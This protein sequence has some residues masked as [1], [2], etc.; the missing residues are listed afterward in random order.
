MILQNQQ[1]ALALAVKEVSAL[2][3]TPA[4]WCI[5]AQETVSVGTNV[6][7]PGAAP[8]LRF[9]FLLLVISVAVPPNAAADISETIRARS[10]GAVTAT[11]LLHPLGS[12][13]NSHGNGRWFFSR[14]FSQGTI[15]QPSPLV[16][17]LELPDVPTFDA[18]AAQ[19]YFNAR[20]CTAV[21][22]LEGAAAI[23][24]PSGG[25]VI[26]MLCH[27]AVEHLALGLLEIFF[28][29][30]PLV[31]SLSHLFNILETVCPLTAEM[32]P[33]DTAENNR[34][35]RLLSAQP[36]SLR[37]A[38]PGKIPVADVEAI[39]SRTR[40]FLDAGIKAA[41]ERLSGNAPQVNTKS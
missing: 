11:L 12:V 22:I 30:R 13:I 14:V 9:S 41:G 25:P 32:F 28:G 19:K 33:H 39:L 29:Y 36:S 20:R 7:S 37:H 27:I 3:K 35:F 21:A 10:D 34:L 1:D 15:V 8:H 24:I 26:I 5:A 17:G 31:V 16:A 18:A 23:K 4:I 2:V 6:F 38:S 40:S